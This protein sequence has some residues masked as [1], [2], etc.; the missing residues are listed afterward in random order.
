MTIR[1]DYIYN[2]MNKDG[3]NSKINTLSF[4]TTYNALL[5]DTGQIS[6]NGDEGTFNMSLYEGSVLQ[7]G[8]E[9]QYY[10]IASED[11]PNGS[12]VMIAGVLGNRIKFAKATAAAV[13]ANPK[14]ILGIAT[15]EMIENGYGYVTNFGNVNEIQTEPG[16]T[17][18]S[19][20]YFDIEAS[21]VSSLHGKLT[22][23]VPTGSYLKIPLAT[24]ILQSDNSP[25]GR[26]LV[27]PDIAYR[28]EQI[29][30]LY[31]TALADN[32]TLRYNEA[33]GYWFNS[34]SDVVVGDIPSDLTVGGWLHLTG[35]NI[36]YTGTGTTFDLINT[37]ATTLNIGGAATTLNLGAAGSSLKTGSTIVGSSS[38]QDVYNTIATTVNAFGAATTL[39]V[40]NTSGNTTIRGTIKVPSLSTAAG[41]IFYSSDASGTLTRLPKGS[42]GQVLTM[43]SGATAPQWSAVSIPVGLTAGST[44]VGFIN[45]NGTTKAAGQ[46]D[47]GSTAPTSTTRLNYDGYLY[48]TQ[49]W[50]AVFNDYAEFFKK[51]E[52]IEA[53]DVV[54]KNPN[55]EGYIKSKTAYDKTVVGVLSD[56]FGH[57]LGADGN[58]DPEQNKQLY[59]AIGLAGRVYVKVVGDVKVGDLLVSSN[60]AGHAMASDKFIPGTIIGKALSTP[61]D[62][63]V[64]MLIMNM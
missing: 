6:W 26:L 41:D 17:P 29:S 7:V 50:G 32:D 58:L 38:S 45:Y 61:K 39:N 53:A 14:V 56:S 2:K 5:V 63:K 35:S 55:G 28:F 57:I 42:S 54:V 4:D 51:D 33:G 31:L 25:A 12:V 10:G 48:A 46:W 60:I 64:Y 13:T 30:N 27:R 15:T 52:P 22:P 49:V 34:Q 47:G 11:I 62:G 20:L 21:D 59:A 36:T 19:L 16:W 9:V 1:Q 37:Q 23:I 40:G 3:T 43:N 8:Q 24:V 18:G 44:S